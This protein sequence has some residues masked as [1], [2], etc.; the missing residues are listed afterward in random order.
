MK[1]VIVLGSE[2]ADAVD[3][4]EDTASRFLKALDASGLRLVRMLDEHVPR[5][6]T[7]GGDCQKSAPRLSQ[8]TAH[9]TSF[10]KQLSVS[11]DQRNLPAWFVEE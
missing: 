5:A 6:G 10:S 7:R 2:C 9:Q 11:A 4:D 8:P 1:T 3:H